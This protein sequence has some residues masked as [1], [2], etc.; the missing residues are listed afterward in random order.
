MSPATK[1]PYERALGTQVAQLHPVL[2]RYFAA[3]PEDSVG[4]GEGVFDCFGTDRRWLK[5]FL[6]LLARCH[7]IAPGMHHQVPFRIENRS[8][9]GCQTAIRNLD[10]NSGTWSMVDEVSLSQTGQ[11]VN[12]LGQP[13]LVEASFDVAVVEGGM[14]LS[15]RAIGL[16]LGRVRLTVPKVI[17]PVISLSESFDAE[18][19][20]QQVRLTVDMPGLGRI[21]QYRGSFTYRIEKAQ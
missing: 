14:S 8:V 4:I 3:I 21:Y 16:R 2:Q 17:R 11:V 13:D 6:T 7:V 15:S 18:V 1:S 20:R 9:D 12:S 5:P 10:L 19:D